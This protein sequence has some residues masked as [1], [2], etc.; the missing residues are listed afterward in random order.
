[1]FKIVIMEMNSNWLDMLTKYETQR[2]R[3]YIHTN[4]QKKKWHNLHIAHIYK[5]CIKK[6]NQKS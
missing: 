1:M 4:I 2:R 5:L 6:P 3:N